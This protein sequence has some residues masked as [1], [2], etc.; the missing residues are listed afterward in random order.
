MPIVE[1]RP[2]IMLAFFFNIQA[3]ASLDLKSGAGKKPICCLK[4]VMVG[5]NNP[6]QLI[7]HRGAA[8]HMQGAASGEPVTC[9]ALC[10]IFFISE[11][12]NFRYSSQSNFYRFFSHARVLV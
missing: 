4:S 9:G 10:L 5:D 11:A 8:E 3:D 1:K 7:S 12:T 2:C 6:I